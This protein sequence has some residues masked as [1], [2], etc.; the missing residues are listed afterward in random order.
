MFSAPVEQMLQCPSGPF[1]T[2]D[3]RSWNKPHIEVAPNCPRCASSN[4]KFCYYNNYS[5][6]QPRY[7]C[8]GCRRYWTKGG[9]L[10]NVPVGGGCRK[11]RRGK[12]AKLSQADRA[13]MSCFNHN[14]SSSDDTSG[15][16]SSGTDNQPG[17]GNGSD[18]D[19]AAVF[20]KFL[21]NNSSNP[22]DEHDHLDQD[23]EPNLV[24]SSS[25]LN[26][27]DG[28]QNSSK[29]DQDLVEAVDHLLGGL[30]AP[31]HHD[32]QHQQIQEENVQ[33][34]MGINHD[35]QQQDDMNIH[36]F[37][38]QGLLGNDDQVVQDVFWSDDAATTSSLTSSTASFSW[39]PMV[40]LQDLDYSLPSD[41][42][43][44]KIPTN[45]CSD[46]WSSFDFS[47][48]EVFSRS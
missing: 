42:D 33:S 26:D 17:G 29:A 24:I 10:R 47:G 2:M 38:L 19:L 48:F 30:V 23:H 1:I 8:K 31:D 39:Q 13:S 21:N 40:H 43:H 6:S 41:D 45:L 46:N 18:I 9:S 14:S 35:Q 44:M 4:T 11:N 12:A 5:L 20:A 3:K 25:E 7:F 32:H 22:A 34:F 16:Y 15:Q 37:G 28:S 27:V 36:Q